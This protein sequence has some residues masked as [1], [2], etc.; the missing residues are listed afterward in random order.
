MYFQRRGPLW[1]RL[2]EF[3][4]IKERGESPRTCKTS[5]VNVCPQMW[6]VALGCKDLLKYGYRIRH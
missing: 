5:I 1:R 6:N 4:T 2:G 3:S